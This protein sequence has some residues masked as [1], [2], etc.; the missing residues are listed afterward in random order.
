M[1]LGCWIGTGCVKGDLMKFRD[2]I[3]KHE[4]SLFSTPW[5]IYIC[6]VL[7]IAFQ[8]Y[9]F[10]VEKIIAF[11]IKYNIYIESTYWRNADS[12]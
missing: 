3:H 1:T 6:Y 4:S 11:Y 7:C 5:L 2:L 10:H 8:S 12:L 9:L